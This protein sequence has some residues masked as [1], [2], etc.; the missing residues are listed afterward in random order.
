VEL[1]A[2]ALQY[3]LR[4]PAVR[5]VV[6]GAASPAQLRQSVERMHAAIPEALW[7]DLRERALIP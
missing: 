1:P 4:D 6:V 5:T 7:T 2:A 3:T